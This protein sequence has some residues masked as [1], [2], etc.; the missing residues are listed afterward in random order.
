MHQIYEDEGKYNF[1]YQFPK[2]L[3][4]AISS[5][6]ILRI[7]LQTLVLTDKSILQ[8]KYQPTRDLALDMK[9]R[10]LKCINIKYAVFF[11]LNFILLVLFWFYL[12]C[13]NAKYANTQVY[14]IENTFISFGISLVYPFI[15]NIIPACLRISSLEDKNKD[16]SCLYSASQIMQLIF[17]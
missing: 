16:K 2:I 17:V 10:I 14:L 1:S 9:I 8:V 6:I 12:T 11:I 4:S 13:F 3:I 7:I 15:I 5:T